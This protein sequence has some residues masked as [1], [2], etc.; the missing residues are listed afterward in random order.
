[1]TRAFAGYMAQVAAGERLIRKDVKGGRAYPDDHPVHEFVSAYLDTPDLFG[2]GMFGGDLFQ[3]EWVSGVVH[4][5]I[6]LPGLNTVQKAKFEEQRRLEEKGEDFDFVQFTRARIDKDFL[7]RV[8]E[9]AVKADKNKT[10]NWK[11][12][13]QVKKFMIE[14]LEEAYG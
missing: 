2:H 12:P 8:Y 7:A 9:R 14:Q 10:W 6:W 13:G 4:V 11:K 3:I 5:A 1:M